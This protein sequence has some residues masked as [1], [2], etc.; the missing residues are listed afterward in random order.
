MRKVS[1]CVCD[2]S[3]E[4]P[5]L[6]NSLLFIV[7]AAT[8][9]HRKVCVMVTCFFIYKPQCA[10]RSLSAAVILDCQ[11]KVENRH[12]FAVVHLLRQK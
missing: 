12:N 11:L 5:I 6:G 8:K 9:K 4:I 3:S 7:V 10:S 1:P 2:E